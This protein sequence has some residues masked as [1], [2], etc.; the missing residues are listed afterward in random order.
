[1]TSPNELLKPSDCRKKRKKK[2]TKTNILLRVEPNCST[3]KSSNEPSTC[4]TTTEVHV[5]DRVI[6]NLQNETAALMD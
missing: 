6:Y 5:S 4:V 2:Y 1:M 3:G